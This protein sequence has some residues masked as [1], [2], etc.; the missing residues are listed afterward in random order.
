MLLIVHVH[1]IIKSYLSVTTDFLKEIKKTWVLWV[2]Q[3]MNFKKPE[4]KHFITINPIIIINGINSCL[5]FIK[6]QNE[7][8]VKSYNRLANTTAQENENTF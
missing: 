8:E 6:T 3:W 2:C 5:K 7:L 1:K 4:N